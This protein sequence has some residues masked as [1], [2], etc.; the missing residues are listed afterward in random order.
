MRKKLLLPLLLICVSV[1]CFVILF[2]NPTIKVGKLE[3]P[4]GLVKKIPKKDRIDLAIQQEFDMTKDPALG[5]VPRE[6]LMQARR[7][8]DKKLSQ[9]TMTLAAVPGISW[10]ERGPNNVAG[11]SRVSWFD[12]GDAANGYKKVW[13]GGVGGGLWSTPDITVAT[14]VWTKINDFFDNLAIT[15]F[16]QDP[17][18]T[19]TMYAGTGE[20]WFNADAI[21]GLGIWKSADAGVTWNRLLS[22]ANFAYVQDLIIDANGHLYA[23]LRNRPNTT[24]AVG[25]QKSMDG[26]ATWVQV[27]GSPVLGASVRGSDL[28]LAT[29]GDIY[30]SIGHGSIGRIFRSSFSTNSV[31]TGNAG[32]WVDITPEPA[33]NIIPASATDVYDRIELACAP[34]DAN[35]VYG[36][37]EGNGTNDDVTHIKQYDAL[38]NVWTSRTVP[39]YSD[40]VQPYTRAQAWYDLI[41]TVDPLD[42]NT[43]Y[44]GGI[45]VYKSSNSGTNWTRVSDWRGS[46]LPYVHA[47]IHEI[48][49]VPGSSTNLIIGCDGGIFYTTTA[50]TNAPV[51]LEQNDGYNITQFYAAANHP[52]NANYFLAGSQDNGTQQFTTAGLNNT[53]EVTGG[54]GG[55]CHIDQDEPNIQI[56]SYIRNNYFVS[57]D[58]GANFIRRYKNDNGSF[59]NPTD[60]DNAA[61]ILYA[62]NTAGSFFRWLDPATNRDTA[63]VIVTNFGA[64][65][66]R[67]V[68]V[69]PQT[70]NRVYFGLSN[71]SI[72]R[73]DNAN[74]GSSISGTIIRGATTGST[75]SSIAIDPSNEDHMLVTY[76]NYGITSVF[77][78]NNATQVSPS[79]TAVEGNLP[80]MPIRW[81]MFDPR[82]ND[83]ALVA[84]EL[85]V[86]STDNLNGATTDWT[87]TNSGLANVRVDMLQYS[88]ATGVLS[89]A[90]H[91]RGLFTAAI[92]AVTTPDVNFSAGISVLTEQ[93]E[94]TIAGCRNYKDYSINMTIA[95]APIGDATITLN[96]SAGG[97][98]TQG[99]DYDFTTNGNFSSPANSFVFA[100]GLTTPQVITI[101]IYDDAE[102]ENI[103]SFTLNY[104]IS[105][106]TNAQRGTSFQTHNVS[107]NSNDIAP[108]Q[109]GVTATYT[110]GTA[111]FFLGSTTA[112]QPFDAKL[113]S[114]R[115]QMLYRASELSAL[116]ITAGIINSVAFNINKSSIRPYQN[117]QIKMGTTLVNNLVEAGIRTEITTSTVKSLAS[118]A[119]V[120][121]FNTFILDVP[122]AWDGRSNIVIEICYDN[123]TEAP[124]DFADR[125]LGY[126][127]GSSTTQGNLFWQNNINCGNPFTSTISYGSGTK[128]QLRVNV[129]STPTP[130]EMVMNVN[131]AEYLTNNGTYYFYTAS[132]NI[133]NSITGASANLGCVNSTIFEAGIS[134]QSFYSGQRSQKV[135]DITPATNPGATYTVGLYFTAAELD[136]KAPASLKIAKTT[137]ATLAEANPGN[138]TKATTAFTTFGTA[139]VFT[140]TFNGFSKFFL[141]D[142]NVVLPVTLIDFKGKL[143]DNLV[144]LEW[145]TSSEQNSKNF[146]IE[147]S[148]DGVNY[149]KIGS[150]NAAGNSSSR[151]DYSFRD[152]QLSPLNYYRLRIN[153]LDGKNKLSNVVLI[154]NNAAIQ[155]IWVVNN[156]FKDFI[157][158]RFAKA[159][160][161]AKLQLST[162]N[163]AIISEKVFANSSGQIRWNVPANLSAGTY[164]LKAIVDGRVY[165][166]KVIKQ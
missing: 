50:N 21:E 158:V 69:S 130:I 133:L 161:V 11:R 135:F 166:K 92:P 68:A 162:V 104:S 93:T 48:K 137:A 19:N 120:N 91:G 151:K 129:T 70:A 145:S 63:S 102:I 73:V 152:L 116:G 100:N 71:G 149:Y 67:H 94:A 83:W 99:V 5:F 13:T 124:S 163:G 22:T 121:G 123:L 114:K 90:T 45:D 24:H 101:R 87:P 18:V 95:T 4:I 109:G 15:A 111:T 128:P 57:T 44:I 138:T 33:T 7:T 82:N 31:N 134:W 38:T 155:S 52:T 126:Q 84:T 110:I 118:Y 37:F 153:D 105:G 25:V 51:F 1:S 10:T 26:G 9:M 40:G 76:S 108:T 141:V 36:V 14:P 119:T 66:V 2:I 62:G 113:Q 143:G 117:L 88:Q 154:R 150:V 34:N 27:L 39:L 165:T 146:D 56:T 122:F 60:Y 112:G 43:L 16:A 96:I 12:L 8:K 159:A 53:K 81:A 147:K 157:D 23:T 75:V 59:I 74:T 61:N 79:W 148:I 160:T 132:G 140:A 103:E 136:G 125:T 98:A 30:A 41:V 156:P 164:I 78:S 35:I 72:V 86:W 115:N 64:A 131:R 42:A 58:G 139:Y 142:D 127:D 106:T 20:G 54:D 89:A 55:F 6:R 49:Y 46:V 65:V 97:T 47:D 28:E 77:E 17:T 107:I 3:N 29:N 144:L 80:D 85:G 32:T